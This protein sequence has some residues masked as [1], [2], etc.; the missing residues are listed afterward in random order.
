MV[1]V[2]V[3]KGTRFDPIFLGEALP[4]SDSDPT[5]VFYTP[6]MIEVREGGGG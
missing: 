5:F 6:I 3:H 4:L 1:G 2:Q